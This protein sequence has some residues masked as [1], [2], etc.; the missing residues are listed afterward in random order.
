MSS[1]NFMLSLV[2][3]DKSLITLRPG[4]KMMRLALKTFTRG[5]SVWQ[6]CGSNEYPN[7][8]LSRNKGNVTIFHQK[9]FSFH[10]CTT[11]SILQRRINVMSVFV[12]LSIFFLL[13]SYPS[14]SH[15]YSFAH[16][17]YIILFLYITFFLSFS[18]SLSLS[19]SL[20]HC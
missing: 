6:D 3:N 4:L 20:F 17:L 14:S 15:H 13:S 19:L 11:Y 18:R 2:D 5:H 8:A 1:L 10:S 12:S 9:T 7:S 16:T